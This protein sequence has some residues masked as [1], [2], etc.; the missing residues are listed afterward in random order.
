MNLSTCLM[1]RLQQKGETYVRTD[2]LRLPDWSADTVARRWAE[3]HPSAAPSAAPPRVPAKP[4]DAVRAGSSMSR[5]GF[6]ENR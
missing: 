4:S 2:P 3:A 1:P 6:I 5:A